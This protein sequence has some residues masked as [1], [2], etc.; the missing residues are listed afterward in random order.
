MYK[1]LTVEELK[2]KA[3][4]NFLSKEADEWDPDMEE[5]EEFEILDL[6]NSDVAAVE[7]HIRGMDRHEIELL[8]DSSSQW[9]LRLERDIARDQET[10]SGIQ[11]QRRAAQSQMGVDKPR[12]ALIAACRMG[13][14]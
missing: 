9:I 11:D 12:C 8:V 5:A 1:K 13:Q 2:R 14:F 6:T 4:F 7:A 10:L 3:L